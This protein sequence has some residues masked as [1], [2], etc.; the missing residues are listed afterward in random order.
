[1]RPSSARSGPK[2]LSSSG[3]YPTATRRAS[4]TA[5]W[6]AHPRTRRARPGGAPG[7]PA[8]ARGRR[9]RRMRALVASLRSQLAQATDETE[10]LCAHSCSVSCSR[11]D[12][13]SRDETRVAGRA[14]SLPQ[15]A[16]DRLAVGGRCGGS[17]SASG[18]SCGDPEAVVAAALAHA[19]LTSDPRRRAAHLVQAAGQTLAAQGAPRGT[20]SECLARAGRD[21]RAGAR[22]R[23]RGAPCCR[24]ARRRARARRG[25][26][27]TDSSKRS[28]GAFERARASQ[29]VVQLGTETRAL[30]GGLDPPDRLAGGRCAA[31]RA[32]GARPG[33]CRR[34][35]P[36]PTNARR[37][38]R[39][40]T[41]STP[42]SPSPPARASRARVWR[43]S[44]T[45][46]TCSGRSS[47]APPTW[48]ASCGR[49]L[50]IDPM[51]V[52]ALRR[53]LAHRRADGARH[54][55]D[56][57][58]ARA[59]RRGGDRAEAKATV[60]T[61][62]AELLRRAGDAP[63]PRRRWSRR[64]RS[65][66]RRRVCRAWPVCSR[67]RRRITPAR[68]TPSWLAAGSSIDPTP[69][70]FAALGRLEVDALGR[71]AEG[72]GHLRL[73][74]GLAPG[75]AR[76]ARSA[77]ARADASARRRRGDQPRCCRCC[78]PDAAPLLSLAD[79]GRGSGDARDGVRGRRAVTTRR[80]SC[81]SSAPSR[82]GSMTE[83]TPSCARAGTRATRRRRSRPSSTR[84][85]SAPASFRRACPRC[86]STS[87]RPSR[88]HRASSRAWTWRS[89][90]SR[91]AAG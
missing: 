49:A 62:L 54:G 26:G 14:P 73:A 90:V 70:R 43:R 29:V 4:S 9:M 63:A 46:P 83:P 75:H 87:P 82:V 81:A 25:R 5:S 47:R 13:G 72:V 79:P 6:S 44:S 27:A 34:C 84:R 15:G 91:R 12:A 65:R 68:S 21:A 22:R 48:S 7:A 58:L 78:V 8:R 19:E 56:R 3:S 76:G 32:R 88:A 11:P 55:R 33:N 39:G 40:A 77:G 50:D 35:A 66:R 80:P 1:M 16:R 31:A 28:A 38:R 59:P 60:L 64:R 74:V 71:W 24:L 41:R 53:L 10:R 61:E 20:R 86:S 17:R 52:E 23:P 36:S 30:R 42:S 57:D 37:W 89:W 69:R 51:S 67:A 45:S 2:R 18:S 85:C